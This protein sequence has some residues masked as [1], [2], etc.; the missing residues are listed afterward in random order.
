MNFD[1][2]A[3]KFKARQA[4][5]MSNGSISIVIDSISGPV[6]GT[7]NL[8]NTG[9]ITSFVTD[10]C[11]L[12][13][14]KGVHDVYLVFKGGTA[15]AGTRLNWFTFQ[16]KDSVPSGLVETKENVGYKFNIFP[17]PAK[18]DFL[19]NYTLPTTSDVKID[20]YTIEG[21]LFKS[22]V[23][24]NQSG[25]NQLTMNANA[26]RMTAGIYVVR[27]TAEKYIKSLLLNINN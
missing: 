9:S 20:I 21:S 23:Q 24:K 22:K 11:T 18:T 13:E 26:E 5:L 4:S 8:T 10:S 12:N 6:A 2:S 19:I 14:I 7:L 27:L 25:D 1:K 16:Q 15:T 3:L 17:N